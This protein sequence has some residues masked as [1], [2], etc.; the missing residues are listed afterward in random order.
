MTVMVVLTDDASP[1][2]SVAVNMTV[3]VPPAVV[4][5]VTV[6][7]VVA[8]RVAMLL[9]L[10]IVHKYDVTVRPL[11]AVDV[12]ASRVTVPPKATLAADA[13]TSAA[14][15]TAAATARDASSSPAPHVLVVQ[16]HSSCAVELGAWHTAVV[17]ELLVAK[18]RVV[19]CNIAL[20]CVGVSAG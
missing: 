7:P 13:V 8:L 15:F 18:P 5:S 16:M 2:E 6:G 11:E 17:V 14:G 19:L 10:V 9:P 1:A 3:T 20:A 4:C 12:D